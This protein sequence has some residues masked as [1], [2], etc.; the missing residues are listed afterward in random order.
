MKI[1]ILIALILL[2]SCQTKMPKREIFPGVFDKSYQKN[3]NLNE[4]GIFKYYHESLSEWV[5][6][7]GNLTKSYSRTER[8]GSWLL[9]LPVVSFFID[10]DYD[11]YEIVANFDKNG[12]VIDIK[13][14]YHKAK[15]YP[16]IFC[17]NFSANCIKMIEFD[18]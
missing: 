12:N 5:D 9:Y 8:N 11:N 6:L 3:I 18:Q 15:L 7:N 13:S 14:F 4:N 16:A 10:R 1:K 2:T 17:D